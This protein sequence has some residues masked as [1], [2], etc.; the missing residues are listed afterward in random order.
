[1]R[2]ALHFR[3]RDLLL[4]ILLVGLA[5]TAGRLLYFPESRQWIHRGAMLSL[6]MVFIIAPCGALGALID[7]TRAGVVCGFVAILLL[8]LA[9]FVANA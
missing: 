3:V 9:T 1:M 8:V 6:A 4:L 2:I 5:C 7:R